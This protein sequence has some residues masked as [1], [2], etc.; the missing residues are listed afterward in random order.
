MKESLLKSVPQVYTVI[1]CVYALP[2]PKYLISGNEVKPQL[3]KHDAGAQNQ[4]CSE[5]FRVCVLSF[6]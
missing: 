6:P 4:G 2:N 1:S 3:S 5:D